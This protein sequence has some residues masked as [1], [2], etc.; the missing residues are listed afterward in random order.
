MGV[1]VWSNDG[2][3]TMVKG[4]NG[5]GWSSDGVV[6]WRGG[7]IETQL[8]GGKS[9]QCW[10]DLFI[11][12]NGVSR[13]VRGGWLAVVMRIQCFSFDS[14]GK[15][16]GWSIAEKWS[17]GSKLVLVQWEESVTRCGGMTMSVSGGAAP[18]RWKRGDDTSWVDVN[19]TEPKNKEN[20]SGR[21][22]CFKLGSEG[23]KQWWVNLFFK[24]Y[25]S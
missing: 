21:F 9:G 1:I 10:D 17:E 8:R 18:T 20:P 11:A 24:I 19:L 4:N 22:S 7:K 25:A 6:L 5:S 12:V 13:T 15:T 14:R 2:R 3:G 23:L 16:T